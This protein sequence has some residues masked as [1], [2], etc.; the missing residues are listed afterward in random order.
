V[1]LGFGE[2]SEMTIVQLM[3]AQR[4][5]EWRAERKPGRFEWLAVPVVCVFMVCTILLVF[6]SCIVAVLLGLFRQPDTQA[7]D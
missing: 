2:M 1:A 4:E 3:V 6:V 7:I 5:R